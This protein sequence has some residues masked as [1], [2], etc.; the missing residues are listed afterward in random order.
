MMMLPRAW[1]DKTFY[2]FTGPVED[3]IQHNVTLVIDEEVPVDSLGDYVDWQ[4]LTLEAELGGFWLLKRNAVTLH[5][6]IPACRLIYRWAPSEHLTLYQEQLFVLYKQTGYKLA[7]SF[8]KKTRKSL[9]PMVEQV[10]LSFD[11][12]S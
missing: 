1:K 10:M 3:D 4:L 7:S 5:N 12:S 6:G 9:G 11:P 2:L 8:T